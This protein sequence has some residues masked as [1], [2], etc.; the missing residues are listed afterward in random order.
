MVGDALRFEVM[1][2]GFCGLGLGDLGFSNVLM[3]DV[4]PNEINS[5]NCVA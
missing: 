4:S 2:T 5:D 3:I 1:I